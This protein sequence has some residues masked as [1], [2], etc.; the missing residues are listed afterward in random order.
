MI[1][2]TLKKIRREYSRQFQDFIKFIY[3]AGKFRM[4]SNKK[5]KIM[6]NDCGAF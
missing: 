2:L 3:V 1:I 5:K 6:K 4:L